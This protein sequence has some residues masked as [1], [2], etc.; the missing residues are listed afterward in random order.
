MENDNIEYH[1]KI[2]I[3]LKV[4]ND[5]EE[6]KRRDIIINVINIL[7]NL[8]YIDTPIEIP[9]LNKALTGR[10]ERCCD[11]VLGELQTTGY[12]ENVRKGYWKITSNGKNYRQQIRELLKT[13]SQTPSTDSQ[14]RQV[15]IDFGQ[16]SK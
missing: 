1:I 15:E 9:D 10:L 14:P 11:T 12:I 3:M 2:T 5:D 13:P 8:F 7:A 4:L 6:H 16:R